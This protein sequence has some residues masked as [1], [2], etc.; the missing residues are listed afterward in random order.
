MKEIWKKAEEVSVSLSD[1]RVVI[2]TIRTSSR[3]SNRIGSMY[4]K[5]DITDKVVSPH[6]LEFSIHEWENILELY[7]DNKKV[8]NA[9][10]VT[11][12]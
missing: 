2:E 9:D 1:D 5:E 8:D 3:T 10:M 11:N 6:T 7:Q 12:G 4:F